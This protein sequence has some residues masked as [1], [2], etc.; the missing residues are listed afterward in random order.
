M[1]IYNVYFKKRVHACFCVMFMQFLLSA[2]NTILFLDLWYAVH[3]LLR[4]GDVYPKVRMYH[5]LRRLVFTNK[6]GG[7]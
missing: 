1:I 2:D 4:S 5:R 7:G 6:I 3:F